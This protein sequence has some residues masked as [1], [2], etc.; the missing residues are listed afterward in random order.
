M[1]NKT[2]NLG[3][4]K[5]VALAVDFQDK[6]F[7]V[8]YNPEE[9]SENIVRLTKGLQALELPII[10]TQQYT[11]GLGHTIPALKEAIEDFSY[12]EKISFSALE[13]DIIAA[14]EETG[15]SQVVLFGI[16]THIC[17]QQTAMGLIDRG[18][19]VYLAADCCSSRKK[20]D[21]K[22]ALATIRQAGCY[23][24]TTESI[25][26]DIL[27]TPKADGFKQVSNIIK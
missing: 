11:K 22:M 17:V 16:E 3:R 7:P 26:F 8:M 24:T 1:M 15:A 2:F 21:K 4:S 9:L 23:V 20:F 5:T 27:K 19:E 25:L 14:I 12:I 10:V 18:Y 6:L 13:E